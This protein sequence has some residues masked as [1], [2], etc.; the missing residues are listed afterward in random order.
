MEVDDVQPVFHHQL[1][2]LSISGLW[3]PALPAVQPLSHLRVLNLDLG[4]CDELDLSLFPNLTHLNLGLRC[5]G[6]AFVRHPLT[7]PAM[8]PGLWKTLR[9]FV[10]SGSPFVQKEVLSVLSTSLS[11]SLDEFNP[12]LRVLIIELRLTRDAPGR[13]GRRARGLWYLLAL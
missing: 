8:P 10:L 11:V 3:I 7:M 4:D 9:T 1:E 6:Q 12:R 2:S 5:D 13:A